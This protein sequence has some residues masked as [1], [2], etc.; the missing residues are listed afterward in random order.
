MHSDIAIS[1]RN[2]SKKFKLFSSPKDRLLEA[3]HPLRKKYHDEFWAL[4]DVSFD[5]SRGQTLGILGRNGSGKSTLLQLIAGIFQPT[6]G[7]VTVNGRVSA[8]L[9]LGAGFNPDF[10]GR[11]NVLL[12]GAIMGVSRKEMLSKLPEIEEFA[13]VGE[14][15]DQPVKTYSSGMYV[16]VAFAAAISVTPEI[17]IIDEALAVG[18]VRFQEKCFRQI[19]ALREAG[20]TI[21]FVSHDVNIF[22]R[23][24]DKVVVIDNGMVSFMGLPA[25]SVDQYF[26]LLYSG[27]ISIKTEESDVS[28]DLVSADPIKSFVMLASELDRF[29]HGPHYNPNEERVCSGVARIV[30]YLL[31]SDGRVI[32]SGALPSGKTISIYLK[33][34][35]SK[36]INQVYCGYA[37][38]TVD[39]IKIFSESNKFCLAD[40]RLRLGAG[41]VVTVRF[42]FLNKLNNG[43][44]FINF[45]VEHLLDSKLVPLDWRRSALSVSVSGGRVYDGFFDL[46]AA[47][48]N[49]I[50]AGSASL[51]FQE[52]ENK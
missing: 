11:D 23:L 35:S 33:I 32:T 24:C 17:L 20:G 21:I 39:G 50:E 27:E 6:S 47:P 29:Q 7:H 42:D 22:P 48:M 26:A 25:E 44:Y 46:R 16:R 28:M 2:I 3:L 19:R 8:L 43:D 15:F 9:E 38:Y 14:F 40:K 4:S 36:E 13:D 1:V 10:T 45:G 30:D 37:I 51:V 34:H 31:V 5:V 52:G 49:I 18:D 12:N 41:E